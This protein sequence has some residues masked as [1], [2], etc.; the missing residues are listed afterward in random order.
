MLTST[1]SGNSATI[2]SNAATAA[3]ATQTVATNL[4]SLQS[5]FGANNSSV[6][7]Q[8]GT[9]STEQSSTA[10]QV[11]ALTSTVAGNTATIG[12]NATTAANATQTV[13]GNLS[14]LQSSFNSS[15]ASV[16]GQIS[17]LTTNTAANAAS[18]LTLNSN[19]AGNAATI[20]QNAT[21][22]ANATQTVATNLATLQS[23]YNGQVSSYNSQIAT[24]ST[25]QSSTTT[26]VT[27]LQSNF[28]AGGGSANIIANSDLNGSDGWA[29]FA[30]IIAGLNLAGWCPP[31]GT[32]GVL[33]AHLAGTPA[34]GEG[35]G[36]TSPSYAVTA[37]V[38]YEVSMYVAYH[39]MQTVQLF[40]VTYNASQN[41]IANN[42]IS[43]GGTSYNL[44][45]GTAAANGDPANYQQIGG[46]ITIP[47]GTGYLG[48][49]VQG[50]TDGEGEPYAF[51]MRPTIRVASPGQ[52]ALTPY[53]S[54]TQANV[55]AINSTISNNYTTLSTATQTVAG[56]L[57]AFQSTYNGNSAS[58]QGQ[59]ST[60]SNSTT[61]NASAIQMLQTSVG[62]NSAAITSNNTAQTNLTNSVAGNLSSFQSTY[63]NQ[64]ASYNTQLSNLTSATQSASTNISTLQASFGS[65][66]GSGNMIANSDMNGIDNYGYGS[67]IGG[68]S[69]G[70]VALANNQGRYYSYLP[71][72]SGGYADLSTPQYA[73]TAGFVYEF[74][75]AAENDNG[76]GCQLYFGWV[77]D[78]G[79]IF[80]YTQIG[81]VNY[82]NIT[83]PNGIPA[84]RMGG[85]ATAPSGTASVYIIMRHV[86]SAGATYVN[87][88]QPMLRVA[89]PNQT[90]LSPYSP[91]AQVNVAAINSNIQNQ[92]TV[93]AN[94]TNTVAAQLNAL[95]STY[96][97]QVASYNSQIATLSGTQGTQATS[98]TTLNTN[99]GNNSASIS[100]LSSSVNGISAKYV[101]AA[102][103]DGVTGG[104]DL[105][106]S[107]RADGTGAVFA[108][109]INAN[110]TINGNLLVSG[111]VG[112][113]KISM[114]KFSATGSTVAIGNGA[115][116]AMSAYSTV[117]NMT[118]DSSFSNGVFTVG[119]SGA[120]RYLINAR[121][122]CGTGIVGDARVA[123]SNI[124]ISVT[125]NGNQFCYDQSYTP[126]VNA[127]GEAATTMFADLKSGD[128]LE[129]F[130]YQSNTNNAVLQ[131]SQYTLHFDL[132]QVSS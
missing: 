100:T 7:T 71:G 91:G 51:F 35:L 45:N 88:A 39:R 11:N 81:G 2:I 40:A 90:V 3:T 44:T 1:V 68:D 20:G 36:W 61:S 37:G 29:A 128:Q 120:G 56:N 82:S 114:A 125:L 65:G 97:G 86:Q 30:G 57:S 17:T 9:L 58:V 121:M 130:L 18:I 115:N 84:Y 59:I 34:S 38:R 109:N 104:L 105:Q 85:F 131:S 112:S 122:F 93:A 117:T 124:Y 42:Y 24:L 41:A 129:V 106:G 15:I 108:L 8:I 19:V 69:H 101:L 16:Q 50:I 111:S 77:D 33:W 25:N 76:G 110:V 127:V 78:T 95:T 87:Y 4:A 118:V 126:N 31:S 49:L 12:T 80:A 53:A 54:G 27:K 26:A 64:I 62:N 83:N 5:S 43:Q 74:S 72:G 113:T 14:T 119:P 89:S 96:N 75:V 23:T 13:A 48:I 60:L 107:Q 55:A 6:Q 73:A 28:A 47:A 123:V 66:T 103:I 67:T 98:I 94:A 32:P 116:T 46:F 132:A 63:N 102:T 52:T 22:A 10:T 99:V 92:A 79:S 70:V 21:T